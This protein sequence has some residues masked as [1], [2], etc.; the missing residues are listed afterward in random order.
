MPLVVADHLGTGDYRLAWALVATLVAIAGVLAYI[1]I[2]ASQ[3]AVRVLA[4]AAA[5]TMA[6]VVVRASFNWDEVAGRIDQ[7]TGSGGSEFRSEFIDDVFVASAGA[8]A[9]WL[10][11]LLALAWLAVV[12]RSNGGGSSA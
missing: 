8:P 3:R 10:L 6:F 2:R 12:R 4:G 9:I 1:A 5:A 11:F 7:V